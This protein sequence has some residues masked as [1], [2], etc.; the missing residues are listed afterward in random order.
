MQPAI[1]RGALAVVAGGVVAAAVYGY[2]EYE[3]LRRS[4]PYY[5]P[6]KAS[7]YRGL[8]DNDFAYAFLGPDDGD[9]LREEFSWLTKSRTDREK[10]VALVGWIDENMGEAEVMSVRA[11]EILESESGACEIHPMAIGV[12]AAFDVKA[13]WIGTVQSSIGFGYLEA[14]VDG[15]WELFEIRSERAD[16]GLGQSA[17]D[18]YQSS[19]PSISIRNFWFKPGQSTSS[20]AGT[21]YP[22]IFPLAN[23]EDHPEL[24]TI[25]TTDEGLDD[26]AYEDVNPYD[27]VYGYFQLADKKWIEEQ[28]VMK[29]FRRHNA[30]WGMTTTR[31]RAELI[32]LLELT[33]LE[34]S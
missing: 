29:N 32:D 22:A 31:W 3:R 6:Y 2:F 26:V 21:V 28:S 14:F 9:A 10:V 1:K 16:P 8:H 23:V 18:L 19:E 34:R 24:E 33:S 17:W 11:T 20:W 4:A 15:G 13:R 7:L 12:L 25:F 5:A 27:F 30:S